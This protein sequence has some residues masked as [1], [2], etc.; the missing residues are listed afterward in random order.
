LGER[1]NFR[2]TTGFLRTKLVAGKAEYSEA[3][4]FFL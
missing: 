4:V 3:V 1:Q 2:I